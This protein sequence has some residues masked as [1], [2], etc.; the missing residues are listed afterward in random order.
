MELT[1]LEPKRKISNLVLFKDFFILTAITI[2]AYC[3]SIK[4]LGYY[5]DDHGVYVGYAYGAKAVKEFISFDRPFAGAIYPILISFLGYK[6][7]YWHI[8]EVVLIWSGGVLVYFVMSKISAQYR[9][10]SL[11]I[12]MLFILYP[13]FADF[14]LAYIYNLVYLQLVFYLL[15]IV[16]MISY[17]TES[18]F[19]II[20]LG[21]SLLFQLLN[22]MISEYFIGLEVGRLIFILMLMSPGEKNFFPKKKTYESIKKWIPYVIT[23]SAFMVY[24]IFLFHPTRTAIDQASVINSLMHDPGKWFSSKFFSI[25]VD[26]SY[27]TIINWAQCIHQPSPVLLIYTLLIAFSFILIERFFLKRI[28]SDTSTNDLLLGKKLV[29]YGFVFIVL[30]QAIFWLA[31]LQRDFNDPV[32]SRYSLPGL[33]GASFVITG[34]II[35]LLRNRLHRIIAIGIIVSFATL[36]QYER[37]V[38][39]KKYAIEEKNFLREFSWRIPKVNE[40]TSFFLVLDPARNY[41][42]SETGFSFFINGFYGPAKDIAKQKYWVFTL[43]ELDDAKSNVPAF[44]KNVELTIKDRSLGFNGNTSKSITLWYHGQGCLRVIDSTNK[45]IIPISTKTKLAA[46]LSNSSLISDIETPHSPFLDAMEGK[47]NKNCWCYY[48]EKS[49]LARQNR[50]WKKVID[51]TQ[52]AISKN[53]APLDDVE[54]L[55]Y[56]EACLNLSKIDEAEKFI[57]THIKSVDGKDYTIILLEKWLKNPINDQDKMRAQKIIKSMIIPVPIDRNVK[58][59]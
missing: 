38:F 20:Y 17:L 15:S 37:G 58:P 40:G 3:L 46:E 4:G 9:T 31:G 1:N 13:G 51:I 59:E 35:V 5:W 44:V 36:F 30:G 54:W 21:F 26:T 18:R 47:E 49:E 28:N 32:S 53:L 50:D 39:F 41:Y 57:H 10:V 12:A 56:I 24:R 29:I 11:C 33:L 45:D 8:Y 25:I 23:F 42:K 7:L 48:F 22:L 6:P 2:L 55:D 27:N 14:S 19:K 43:Q 52:L 16:L 34:L